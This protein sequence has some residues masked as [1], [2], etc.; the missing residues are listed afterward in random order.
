MSVLKTGVY[1][2]ICLGTDEFYVGS[3]STTFHTRWLT[4]KALLRSNRHYNRRL[5]EAWNEWGEENFKFVRLELCIPTLCTKREQYWVNKLDAKYPQLICNQY[6]KIVRTSLGT[7]RSDECRRQM[8]IDRQGQSPVEATKA[9]AKANRGKTRSEE[10]RKKISESHKGKVMS[11]EH[12]ESIKKAHW[13]TR[14]DAHLIA[15]RS[16]AKNRGRTQ[17]PE[18]IEKKRQANL[19]A[20]AKKKA[21]KESVPN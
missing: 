13:S 8:S 2:I 6:K 14:P 7:K 20:W 18:H 3:A 11:E 16:A 9:A 1:K 4:H 21:L 5:Q 10:V 17:S 12:C 19:R 15:E